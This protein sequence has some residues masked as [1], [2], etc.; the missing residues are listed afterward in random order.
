M[1]LSCAFLVV[2]PFCGTKV[3]A[4]F[5]GQ[6]QIPRL[7]KKKIIKKDDAGAFLPHKYILFLSMFSQSHFSQKKNP[8]TVAITFE[9]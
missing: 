9:L 6:G 3:K 4:I 5:L 7:K 8:L 2:R 1:E